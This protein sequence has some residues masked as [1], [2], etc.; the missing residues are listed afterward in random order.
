MRYLTP[1]LTAGR[2]EP[3]KADALT[4]KEKILPRCR[5][6]FSS[7]KISTKVPLAKLPPRKSED[8]NRK[9]GVGGIR[10]AP[11]KNQTAKARSKAEKVTF[12]AKPPG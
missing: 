10:S 1:L 12:E 5:E 9:I 2:S 7:A 6:D 11:R 3:E 8:P 4:A